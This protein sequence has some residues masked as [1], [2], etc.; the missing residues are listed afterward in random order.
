[1]SFERDGQSRHAYYFEDTKVA[2]RIGAGIVMRMNQKKEKERKPGFT[3][4]CQ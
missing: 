2:S 1:M 4:S 3:Q